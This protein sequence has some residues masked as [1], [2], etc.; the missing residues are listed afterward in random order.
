M[1][2][3]PFFAWNDGVSLAYQVFGNGP[4]DL[5]YMPGWLSNVDIMWENNDYETF[6]RRL[7]S[8]SRLIVMDR[9]GYGCSERFSPNEVAPLEVHVDDAIAVLNAVES[10]RAAFFSFDEGTF[11]GCLLAASHPERVSHLMLLD[12]SPSWT[13][14]EEITWEWSAEDWE[15]KIE[16]DRREWG[17]FGALRKESP[18]APEDALRW[19]AKFN[20]QSQSAGAAAAELKRISQTDIRSVLPSIRIPTLIVH[21]N[22]RLALP[23]DERSPRYVAEHTPNAKYIEVDSEH[24][25]WSGGGGTLCDEIERFLTGT[26]S[27]PDLDRIHMTVMFTDIVE[28]TNM[29]AELGDKRSRQLLDK[30]HEIVRQELGRF[31]GHEVDTAGDSFFAT[32]DGSSRAVRCAKAIGERVQKE[33]GLT[34]RAGV[35][36][37]EVELPPNGPPS[38]MAV[39]I[40][41]RVM[42]LAGPNEVLATS[43][44]R[45]LSVGSGLVFEDA[46]EHELKGVPDP[47]RLYKV[48]N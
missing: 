16:K 11:I 13:S 24:E 14:N 2:P 17:S 45:N 47:W 39:N 41:A 34:I 18:D 21:G 9:R 7:A 29:T 46:G 6:L 4:P 19:E 44:V 23:E 20:R 8:F 3:E 32:F 25:P 27:H 36:T 30:H 15:K 22:R 26:I 12:P 31:K 37:G 43:N 40:G 42:D 5:L 48:V 28:S 33:I 35:H 1:G 38:G 10:E